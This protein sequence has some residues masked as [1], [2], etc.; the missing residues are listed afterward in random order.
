MNSPQT[1][2]LVC[3]SALLKTQFDK[4]EFPFVDA[5]T[6]VGCRI[7]HNGIS[8]KNPL[9][10]SNNLVAVPTIDHAVLMV[11]DGFRDHEVLIESRFNIN[12][13]EESVFELIRSLKPY[14]VID[15]F[16]QAEAISKMAAQLETNVNLEIEIQCGN[17]LSGVK[18]GTP[19][20]ELKK[21]I[22]KLPF[23]QSVGYLF[24]D[25]MQTKAASSL[26]F[27]SHGNSDTCS[28]L[29]SEDDEANFE[30]DTP[31]S[32]YFLPFCSSNPLNAETVRILATVTSRP[33]RDVAIINLGANHFYS[34]SEF[35]SLL[36][37]W[38]FNSSGDWIPLSLKSIS[39]YEI[40]IEIPVDCGNVLIGD[41][42]EIALMQ[43]KACL[44]PIQF[45]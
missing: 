4:I 29:V 18:P 36:S 31:F 26:K 28:V 20:K 3:S 25:L 24:N 5:G 33:R 8:K 1:P 35:P 17:S 23:I 42:V 27:D 2:S 10:D 22:E 43:P 15:H 30:A 44:L 11:R 34:G 16:V 21:G 39:E 45:V 37:H 19:A 12:S 6:I 13:N 14:F 40:G 7:P 9:I 41:Q 32:K 38:R